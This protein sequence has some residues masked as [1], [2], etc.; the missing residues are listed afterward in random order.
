MPYAKGQSGNPAGKPKGAANKATTLAR[1]AIALF[2]DRN[3]E[4][5][6]GWLDDIAAEDPQAAFDSFMKVVEYHVPKLQR[7]EHTGKDGKE[8]ITIIQRTIVDPAKK[9]GA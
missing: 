7:T 1:E 5:L 6:Q 3:T 2:V 4:R 8:E 9:T